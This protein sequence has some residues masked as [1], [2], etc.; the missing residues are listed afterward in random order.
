[1]FQI[2]K[3]VPGAQKAYDEV[4]AYYFRL[5]LERCLPPMSSGLFFIPDN[6]K[7]QEMCDKAIEDEPRSLALVTD[8]L[9]A[10]EM[11]EKAVEK[12]PWL[13]KY[14]PNWFVTQEPVKLWHDDYYYCNNDGFIKW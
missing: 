8:H 13:L 2:L 9:K 6:I 7:T 4:V 5:L 11:F 3:Y 14:V 1:M 12:D 10:Q